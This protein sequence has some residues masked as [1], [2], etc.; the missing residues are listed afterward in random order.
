LHT[1]ISALA[2]PPFAKK[3]TIGPRSTARM[4]DLRIMAASSKKACSKPKAALRL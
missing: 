1:L 3:R 2:D 4:P